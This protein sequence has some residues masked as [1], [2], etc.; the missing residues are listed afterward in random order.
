MAYVYQDPKS[1]FWQLGFV[2][3]AGEADRATSKIRIGTKPAEL[4]QSKKDAERKADDME[5]LALA[6]REGRED[7]ALIQGFTFDM[8]AAKFTLEH[9]AGLHSAA[10]IASRMKHLTKHF[11]PRML[12]SIREG[13]VKAYLTKM[14]TTPTAKVDGNARSG[15]LLSL[16]SVE[17][18]RR[19]LRSMFNF[20]IG[21]GLMKKNPVTKESKVT[22]EE[23]P[24]RYLELEQVALLLRHAPER[25]RNFLAAALYL[26]LR[27]GEVIA[28]RATNVDL[29]KMVVTV[30]FSHGKGTKGGKTRIV[31]IPPELVPYLKVE[32]GRVRS[33]YLFPNAKGGRQ[34]KN[35]KTERIIRAAAVAAGLISGFD[36][37]C[38]R[39]GCGYLERRA[40]GA[41]FRCPDC[42]M[43][44]HVR[45]IPIDL[46]FKDARSTW[47]T[48][49]YEATNDFRFVQETLG[50]ADERIT[51]L[52][53]AKRIEHLTK[54]G[55]KLSFQMSQNSLRNGEAP[56]HS[57]AVI[58]NINKGFQMDTECAM[59]ESNP[60]PLAPET[61]GGLWDDEAQPGITEHGRTLS[62]AVALSG[63]QDESPE[64]RKQPQESQNQLRLEGGQQLLT[65]R[66]VA[67]R[68]G[69][70][71]ETVRRHIWKG[72][73]PSI[74]IG[75]LVRVAPSD[76]EAFLA[77]GEP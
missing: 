4:R 51:N 69:V 48:H 46:K 13:D 21:N 63:G 18:L 27:K 38:R 10:T 42:N 36:H 39:K 34:S 7:P 67:A 54:Q 70:N 52:Y 58:H 20:A 43:L 75:N 28:L 25:W 64:G 37:L 57:G 40:D 61:A 5:R 45:P 77:G 53:S 35:L 59:G 71:A 73:L 68:L 12:L 62:T 44:L 8:L 56:H 19:Q 50:H 60:R 1:P 22:P 26:G 11:G 29:S 9:A 32:L 49:A 14:K 76:L 15:D 6:Q 2:N 55:A 74:R 65:V 72:R 33:E 41:Q 47:A 23:Q 30:K 24:V 16:A 66:E 3:A 31:P 17:H